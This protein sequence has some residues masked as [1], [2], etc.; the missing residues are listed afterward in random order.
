M[1]RNTLGAAIAAALLSTALP[2]GAVTFYGSLSNFD[3]LNDNTRPDGSPEEAEGFEIELHGV[4]SF[5]V[6][7]TF[8]APTTASAIRRS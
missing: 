5:D 2:A 3:V 7:Y 1:K 4:S 6:S 8:G